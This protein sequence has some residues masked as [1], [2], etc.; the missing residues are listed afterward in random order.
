M[1]HGK[2][3]TPQCGFFKY[4]YLSQ[5]GRW[6][7]GTNLVTALWRVKGPMSWMLH[8]FIKTLRSWNNAPDCGVRKQGL[9]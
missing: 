4:V 2:P 5:I 1:I 3:N 8:S 9:N 7:A 6:P